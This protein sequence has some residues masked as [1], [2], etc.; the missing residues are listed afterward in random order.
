MDQP[1][2]L[3]HSEGIQQLGGKHF[4]ELGAQALELVLFDEFVK[5]G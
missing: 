5:V 4:D 1:C 3:E 2:V